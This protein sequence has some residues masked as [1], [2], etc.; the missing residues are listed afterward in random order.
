MKVNINKTAVQVKL[1]G[2]EKSKNGFVLIRLTSGKFAWI[3][4]KEILSNLAKKILDYNEK[5]R[6]KRI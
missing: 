1:L 2:K 4:P 5:K 6:L 3:S